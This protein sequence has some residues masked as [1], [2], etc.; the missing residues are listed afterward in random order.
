MEPLLNYDSY[1]TE[2]DEDFVKITDAKV[3]I[4]KNEGPCELTEAQKDVIHN[5]AQMTLSV[6]FSGIKMRDGKRV[7]TFSTKVMNIPKLFGRTT[8][9]S[10]M[11]FD[12]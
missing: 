1:A 2:D 5:A 8:A 3:S 10:E 7:F 4:V 12:S 11:A 9:D 6:K